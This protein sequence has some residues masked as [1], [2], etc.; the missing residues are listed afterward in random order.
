MQK[1]YIYS[2]FGAPDT[3]TDGQ[4]LYLNETMGS[5]LDKLIM[6]RHGMGKFQPVF[7]TKL[8][9]QEKSLS[10]ALGLSD[11]L[12]Y[13][14]DVLNCLQLNP[15]KSIGMNIPVAVEPM[16]HDEFIHFSDVGIFYT[17]FVQQ[18]DFRTV[19]NQSLEVEKYVID[20]YQQATGFGKEF[21]PY[22][23]NKNWKIRLARMI[24]GHTHSMNLL[25]GYNR[26]EEAQASVVKI[27]NKYLKTIN[28]QKLSN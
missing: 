12:I 10:E 18:E 2:E 20:N 9:E 27:Y 8:N 17:E 3:E 7:K 26:A 1:L 24:V 19:L 5:I 25:F 23:V 16:G 14:K 22:K 15:D 21:C 28:E 11:I 6:A 13:Q 4:R